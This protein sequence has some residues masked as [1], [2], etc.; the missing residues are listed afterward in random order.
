MSNPAAYAGEASSR[1]VILINNE[2]PHDDVL[3]YIPKLWGVKTQ[4]GDGSDKLNKA[5]DTMLGP[6]EMRGNRITGLSHEY[7][8]VDSNDAVSW[9]QVGLR[10]DNYVPTS[11]SMITGMLGVGRSITIGNDAVKIYRR[12]HEDEDAANKQYVDE[13]INNL[14]SPVITVWASSKNGIV[15]NKYEWYFGETSRDNVRGGYKMLANGRV[16]RGA[17][18]IYFSNSDREFNTN[19]PIARL[20]VNKQEQVNYQIHNYVKSFIPPLELNLNDV[21]NIK[22]VTTI[23]GVVSATISLLIELDL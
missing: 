12:P 8:P 20:V 6:L 22:S 21:L 16:L 7:P 17:I 5:G 23:S 9:R 10:L 2:S 14:P 19:T 15:N 18:N 1:R 4:S 13:R 3:I 11:G